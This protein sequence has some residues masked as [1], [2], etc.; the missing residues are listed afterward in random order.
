MISG[1]KGDINT[2]FGSFT[3]LKLWK[4]ILSYNEIVNYEDFDK[5]QIGDFLDWKT[6]SLDITG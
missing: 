3:D 5:G 4:K 6:I 1:H 2:F